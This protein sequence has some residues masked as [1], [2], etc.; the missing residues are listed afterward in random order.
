MPFRRRASPPAWLAALAL[1]F[2][3]ALVTD[4]VR[5]APAPAGER[6]AV[7]VSIDGLMPASY[8]APDA[9]GLSVPNLRR[10]VAEG[11]SAEGVVGVL[12]SVT[13]PSH[14]TMTTGVPPRLHGI[15]GN[16]IFDP[17][18]D[19]N[20]AWTWYAEDVRVPTLLGAARGR[21]LRT[22]TLFWPVTVGAAAEAVVPEFWRSGSRHA[23]DHW[24][25]DLNYT[26]NFPL[27]E[28]FNIQL[29]ADIFNAFDEQTGYDIQPIRSAA[30]FGLPRR[31]FEPRRL[32][33]AV[34]FEF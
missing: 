33:L 21:G 20:E 6:F 19:S 3:L 28:R 31:L 22:A 13:Y 4:A 26:Q 27:N 17:A 25:L 34:R 18:G 16:R 10:L 15:T 29:R 7:L 14:T 12:P 24:Q 32:Q 30:D 23:D 11:A 5:A 2:V 9:L 8:T 1:A